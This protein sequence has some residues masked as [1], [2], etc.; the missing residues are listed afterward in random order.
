MNY[1]WQADPKPTGF[2]V[3][4]LNMPPTHR[5]NAGVSVV[6]GRYFGSVSGSFV[7]SE[8]WQDVLPAYTGW[9]RPYTVLDAGFGVHSSDR[10]M[11]VAF[12]ARNLFNKAIQE[13][14]FGDL[15]KRTLIGEV[16]FRF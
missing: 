8:F 13:H 4:E 15:I 11:T 9:T 3:S 7:D 1:S 16:S 14:F 5:V 2:D 6:H 12:R 10:M